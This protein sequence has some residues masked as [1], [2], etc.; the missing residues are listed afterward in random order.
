MYLPFVDVV[1]PHL[2]DHERLAVCLDLLQQQTYPPE[3]TCLMVV[4]NG[5]D[6]PLD[7]IAAQFPKVLFV[8]ESERGCGSARNCGA[9]LTQ[10]DILAFTDSD[11]RPDKDWLLNGVRRL[12]DRR[13][14]IIGGEIK[15]FCVDER[16][17]TAV[18][19]FDKTFGFEQ[20]R[21]ILHKNFS[22]GA[23][24]MVTREIFQKVGP[25][26]NGTLPE[27]MEWGRRAHSMG[28]RLD[29]APEVLVRHPARRTWEELRSKAKRTVWH[30]RNYMAEQPWF[31]LRWLIYACGVFLPPMFMTW[32]L[33]TVS[34]LG[35][36]SNR[37]KGVFMLFRQRYYRAILM[38]AYLFKGRLH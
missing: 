16:H 35:S 1:I 25:F 18:E 3:R 30:S 15:V 24:I 20:R 28:M 12:M 33:L 4:D 22:A 32:Q 2:N 38:L 6:R 21:Y 19:M 7:E 13:A 23:N 17:P 27:D 34:G 8:S 31:R 11:C 29:F 37:F 26:R 14:E 9:R 5:S 10:G 36:A